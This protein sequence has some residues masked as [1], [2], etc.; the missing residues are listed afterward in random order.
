[1]R[2][3]YHYALVAVL[4]MSIVA[5]TGCTL[6]PEKTSTPD[7]SQGTAVNT[8]TNVMPT[9]IYVS[10][11]NGFVVPLN[12]KMEQ[13]NSIAKSTLEHMVIGGPGDSALSGTGLHNVLPK[14]TTIKG[15]SIN[16]HVARVDF[17]KDVLNYKTEAEE[18]AIV[19]SVVWS[20]TGIEG[21]SKV[22]F[23]IDGHIQPTLKNGTPV[24][25][26]ISRDN[27]INLQVASNVNPSNATK[28]TLYFSGANQQ[29]DYSYLV[30][31]TR[32][33][34]KADPSKM[35]E[36][37]MAELAKGPSVD[38]LEPVVQPTLK[39]QKVDQ[40][41]KVAVLDFGND[42]QVSSGTNAEKNMVNSI[43][44]SVAANTGVQQVQFTVNGKAPTTAQASAKPDAM[45]V[46]KQWM[47]FTKPVTAPKVVN[48]QKL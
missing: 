2:K 8:A 7:S 47:D 32:I 22:Q 3:K 17:S 45:N 36:L 31:V 44:L 48:E 46:S 21:I 13:T 39:L 16:N 30:P 6:T 11:Q 20:L 40:K 18:H 37:T 10:N 12:I 23:V 15:V 4:A 42:F 5:A 28:L 35:A 41:D 1:M 25:D 43:L 14:G 38:G 34:P 29:G 33:V 27:G 26:A 9:T 19:D 24:A